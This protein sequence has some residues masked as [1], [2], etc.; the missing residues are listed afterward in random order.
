MLHMVETILKLLLDGD[1]F[2]YR[3][4]ASAETN[5]V[6]IAYTY[7]ESLLDTCVLE[8]G[9]DS[10]DFYL[11]GNS[12]FRY[13]IYPE[14]KANRLDQVKPRWLQA[15]REFL[16]KEYGAVVAE[17]CEA[18]DLLGVSQCTSNK[19][20]VDTCIASLDK[21]LLMIPGNHYSWRI[22]GGTPDKRWVK[23]AKSQSI[24]PI[25]GLRWF[26]TQLLTGDTSDNVKGVTGIGKVKAEKLL[27]GLDNEKDLFNRVRDAYSCDEEMLMNASVLWI[28]Q[29]PN[30][31]IL[32]RFK[33]ID[34]S[35]CEE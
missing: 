33:S 28:W 35:F 10:F 23:D 12:N 21:D 29:K 20:G 11:T 9:A 18:D 6:E 15:C 31:A 5:L 4:A 14:Y 22:E 27:Q 24:Q 32:E 16:I 2:C 8:T 1:L 25:D 17:G 7:I 3:C 34:S 19:L 13:Q 30:D 26:Y